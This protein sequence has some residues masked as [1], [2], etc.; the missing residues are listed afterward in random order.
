MPA[1]VGLG[2]DVYLVGAALAGA[3]FLAAALGFARAPR[4][5]SARR[6][7]LTS[8]FYLPAVLGLMVAD[9]WIL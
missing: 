7:L 6:L 3:L 4:V 9:R 1:A 8:V 5:E 2:S